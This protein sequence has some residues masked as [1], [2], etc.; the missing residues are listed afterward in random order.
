MQRGRRASG[1]YL[2]LALLI[3]LILLASLA[4][5]CFLYFGEQSELSLPVTGREA[6]AIAQRDRLTKEF[7]HDNFRKPNLRVTS[8][9]LE[10]DSYRDAYNWNVEIMERICGCRGEDK[11]KI[12]KV[13]VNPY[14]ERIVKRRFDKGIKETKYAKENCQIKC[15]VK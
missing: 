6:L 8:V 4:G 10:W 7:I 13:T 15:H 5:I 14:T 1:F 11:I 2:I 3:L 12:V 9:S